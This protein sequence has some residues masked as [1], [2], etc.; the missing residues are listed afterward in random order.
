MFGFSDRENLE[1]L[2]TIFSQGNLGLNNRA[3]QTK[4]RPHHDYTSVASYIT[5]VRHGC[6]E[7]WLAE[8]TDGVVIVTL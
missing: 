6:T 7:I 4:K 1:V 3:C 8:R 5:P 2:E